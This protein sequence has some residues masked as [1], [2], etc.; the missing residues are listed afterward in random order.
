MKY[1]QELYIFLQVEM[2][3]NAMEFVE[4]VAY[5]ANKCQAKSPNICNVIG[6]YLN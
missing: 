5:C 1:E 2:E 3:N 4:L 6:A